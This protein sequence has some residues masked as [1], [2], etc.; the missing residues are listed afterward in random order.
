VTLKL[1]KGV[2]SYNLDM[3]H[4]IVYSVFNEHQYMVINF[5]IFGVDQCVFLIFH[6]SYSYLMIFSASISDIK[7]MKRS[8]FIQFWYGKFNGT[9]CF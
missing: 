7:I 3:N 5:H 4:L 1:L 2:F 9:I 6:E 8:V